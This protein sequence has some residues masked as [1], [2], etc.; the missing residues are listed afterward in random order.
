MNPMTP[1]IYLGGTRY[2]DLHAEAHAAVK[3]LEDALVAVSRMAPRRCDYP[4]ETIFSAA[5]EAH[6]RWKSDLLD[7][8]DDVDTVLTDIAVQ[9]P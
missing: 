8:R 9:A 3:A 4:T 6:N 1:T 2:W 7:I 5:Q